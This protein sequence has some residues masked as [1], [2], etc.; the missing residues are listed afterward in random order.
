MV[1]SVPLYFSVSATNSMGLSATSTCHLPT[2]DMTL[3]VGRVTPDFRSTSHPGLL[4]GSALA[5]DDSV[6][7]EKKVGRQSCAVLL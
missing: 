3:P 2:Y 1:H 7:V 4:H 6:I 5:F